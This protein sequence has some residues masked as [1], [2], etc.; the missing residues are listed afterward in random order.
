MV[1]QISIEYLSH[2]SAKGDCPILD[3]IFDVISS[4]DDRYV[5]MYVSMYVS[6]HCMVCMYV[7]IYVVLTSTVFIVFR[8]FYAI[9]TYI[10]TYIKFHLLNVCMYVH[11]L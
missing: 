6:M 5:Y 1:D 8:R 2:L 9:H 11:V 4:S 10:H 3:N 7:C